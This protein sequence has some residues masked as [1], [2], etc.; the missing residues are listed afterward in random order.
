MFLDDLPHSVLYRLCKY[1]SFHDLINLS[2]TCKQL[3]ILIDQ[4]DYFWMISIQNQLGFK[5]YQRYTHE[6]FRNT[7]NSDYDLYNTN[8]DRE[9]FEK[10]FRK[11]SDTIKSYIWLWN[12]L[13]CKDNSNAYLAYKRIHKQKRCPRTNELKMSLTMNELFEY[14]LLQNK[15]LTKENICQISSYKLVYYYLIQPKRLSCLDLFPI[16]IHYPLSS[17]RF[18]RTTFSKYEFDSNSSTNQCVRLYSNITDLELGIKGTFKSI[19]PGVYQIICRIKLDKNQVYLQQYNKYWNGNGNGNWVGCY[20]YAL[21]D[22]GTD[23]ECNAEI[24]NYDWFESNYCLYGNTKWFNQ[25]MGQII[26]F[27]LSN[28]Y[29]GFKVSA[30][31]RYHNVLFDYIEL[32]IV[33]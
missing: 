18:S 10:K 23:C 24:M 16:V 13:N 29:F 11:I 27:Q 17:L 5:L 14:Y 26:V 19:L 1:L 7:R 6:I 8:E 28:I 30:N 12:V 3:F 9:N 31:S 4:N 2:T 20:F 22:Y 21:S 33:K 15:S 32:N 25:T